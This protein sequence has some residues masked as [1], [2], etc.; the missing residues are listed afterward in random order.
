MLRQL[1]LE[2]GTAGVDGFK[3]GRNRGVVIGEARLLLKNKGLVV[4]IG[5]AEFRISI[6]KSG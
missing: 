5:N 1:L 2:F 4:G 6:V 3:L